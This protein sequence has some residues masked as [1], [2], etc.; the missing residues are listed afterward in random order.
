M[1][2][3]SIRRGRRGFT[4]L[5]ILVSS[6]IFLVIVLVLVEASARVGSL[7]K[8]SAGRI[9]SFQAARA[10]FDAL[11]RALSQATLNTYFDYVDRDGNYRDPL[12]PS[13]FVPAG[14]KRASELHFVCG[15]A[16]ALTGGKANVPG[17]AVFFQAP[18]D[19]SANR[20][21]QNIPGLMN[22]VGFYVAY[23][24]P[25]EGL[26]AWLRL[27]SGNK[28]RFLL[29]QVIQPTED[30]AIYTTPSGAGW[31]DALLDPAQSTPGILAD[32][33]ILLVLRPRLSPQDEIS[34]GAQIGGGA[35]TDELRGS[36]LCPNYAY[37]SRAWQNASNPVPI[38]GTGRVEIMRNQIAP[39][40]DIAMIAVDPVS[41]ARLDM[42]SPT[43]PAELTPDP[44][45]FTDSAK[46]EE[47]L[48]A[49]EQRLSERGFRFRTFR[50]SV[51]VQSSKWANSF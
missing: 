34:V 16:P 29:R 12:N 7:W 39:I 8:S 50:T 36:I 48:A 38:T 30:N 15:D 11:T 49:F 19:Y 17:H 22:A 6:A 35:V 42:T 20:D 9:S 2:T 13:G 24:D 1:N 40:I 46:M 45:S 26:P 33:V 25:S 5:E 23:E 41:F 32:N 51:P 18:M 3:L 27:V 14:F 43:P 21:L 28:R 44:G 37:N 47:D 4:I 10:G 31:I